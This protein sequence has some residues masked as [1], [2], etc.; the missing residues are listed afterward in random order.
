MLQLYRYAI[1]FVFLTGSSILGQN[2]FPILGGQRA[3]TSIYTFLKIG[4][5]AR[6]EGMGEA[7]VALQQ[8][9]ASIYYNPGTIAQFSGTKF[10]ASRIKWPADINYDYF[11]FTQKLAGRHSIG[12][13]AGIL[14][15]E[16]MMETTEYLPHGTGNYFT[17]QDRFIG[18][19][20]G[21]RMTDRFSFG[22]TIKHVQED[23]AGY[24]LSTPM[25]D[26]GTFYWTG[27]KSLRFSASLSHFG[28]QSKPTGTFEKKY[29]DSETGEEIIS[30]TE[31]QE[32][33]TAFGISRWCGNGCD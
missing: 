24:Q 12:F 3:G 14:H 23:L 6:A 28:S 29:L 22:I 8:D 25:M 9:A 16:P 33:F 31:F 7:V 32:F 13:S 4:V 20:Y 19:T 26:M 17:Y 1:V 18:L 2:F 30:Q 21:A 11:A 15:M 5:S 10:S 27:Y